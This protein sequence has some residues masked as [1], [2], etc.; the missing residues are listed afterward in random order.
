MVHYLFHKGSTL[1]THDRPFQ[2]IIPCENSS[3]EEK[4]VEIFHFRPPSPTPY[5]P[6]FNLLLH[7]VRSGY[8]LNVFFNIEVSQVGIPPSEL[9]W[10]NNRGDLPGAEFIV[11]I[12]NILL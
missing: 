9:V 8:H 1:Q 6:P 10:S 11:K 4:S 7:S 5:F 12:F 3:F 2:E